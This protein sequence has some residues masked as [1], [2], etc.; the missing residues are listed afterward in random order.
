[1]KKELAKS[2]RHMQANPTTG[3]PHNHQVISAQ[4]ETI[5]AVDSLKKQIVKLRRTIEVNEKQS[6]ILEQSNMNL[7]RSMLALTLVTTIIASFPVLKFIFSELI[8]PLVSNALNVTF[9][10]D[11]L[12]ILVTIVPAFLSV[13]I[14]VITS[15][16]QRLFLDKIN[17]SDSINI[18]LRDKDGNIKI[19]RGQ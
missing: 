11:V 9:S 14:G 2:L 17:L 1:M 7:Q 4:V 6:Q 3:T 16:Y 10:S 12:T 5:F 13:I 15:R 19:V 18:V 8:S